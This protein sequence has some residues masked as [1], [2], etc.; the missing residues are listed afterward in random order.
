MKHICQD[1]DCA[2]EEMI[3]FAESNIIVEPY[4]DEGGVVKL[5]PLGVDALGSLLPTLLRNDPA[6]VQ[7]ARCGGPVQIIP[8][9]GAATQKQLNTEAA[10]EKILKTLRSIS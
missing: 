8:D 5:R 9:G 4:R 1:P 7:C 2:C 10:G 6:E 3:I